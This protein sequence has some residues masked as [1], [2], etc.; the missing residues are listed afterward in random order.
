[1]AHIAVRVDG[2]AGAEAG[3]GH[4]YR[5]LAY[6]RLLAKKITDAEIRFFMRG[7]P[8]GIAKVHGEGFHVHPLPVK[9]AQA[10]YEAALSAYRPD[11]LVVD[12]PKG[13]P[14]L[15]SAGRM[16]A[17][18]IVAL[19]DVWPTG[20]EADAIVN[21]IL[22]ATHWLPERVGRA[23]VYQGVEYLTLREQFAVANRQLRH[24]SSKVKRIL[25]S[26]GGA[27][28]RSFML[29]L[30]EALR[31][32]PFECQVNAMIGPAYT[33]AAKIKKA[34][35]LMSGRVK[36]AVVE[37]ASN[38]ADYLM[39]A[40]MAIV[41][42]GTVMFESA[43]CGTPAIIVCSYEHQVS[44]AKWFHEHEIS[45]NFG[46]F[47]EAVDRK[48]LAHAVEELAEDLPRRQ[49]MSSAGKRLVDGRGIYRLVDIIKSFLD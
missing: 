8:E 20:K 4:V 1:M 11:L 23:K 16:F 5:S 40:D 42:G 13:S 47:P 46:Y 21:G 3:M 9:P 24:I 38:M 12:L 7:F 30:M 28:G 43:A 33:N 29:Q 22:W 44:Q 35:Q 26:T 18:A 45:L 27:D 19:D 39:A 15:M 2:D 41:T 17:H 6:A 48:L 49:E 32:L 10:D 37:N 25:I 34:A 36:F 14:E 31:N